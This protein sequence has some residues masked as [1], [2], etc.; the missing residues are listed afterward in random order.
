MNKQPTTEQLRK[1]VA[2]QL[3]RAEQYVVER[4]ALNDPFVA[5]ALA[6]LMAS[7]NTTDDLAELRERLQKRVSPTQTQRLGAWF[8]ASAAAVVVGVGLGWVYFKIEKNTELTLTVAAPITEEKTL[9]T[10]VIKPKK[11]GSLA[12]ID[13]PKP[14]TAT[15]YDNATADEEI[16]VAA[17]DDQIKAEIAPTTEKVE[18]VSPIMTK[19]APMSSVGSF[20]KTDSVLL[21]TQIT[22]RGVIRAVDGSVLPGVSVNVEGSGRGVSTDVN[23]AFLLDKIKMGDRLAFSYV[24]FDKKEIVVRD[25]TTQQIVLEEDSKSLN[26]VVV[27]RHSSKSKRATKK[28]VWKSQKKTKKAV[29]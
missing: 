12:A 4:A 28:A 10:E 7:P 5:D 24:G 9:Q 26:E 1:Y 6:G 15:L 14:Q 27:I 8:W 23:G 22:A 13:K 3:S 2:G 21:A 25:S 17:D 29:K 19:A 20:S 11:E 16:I 18:T